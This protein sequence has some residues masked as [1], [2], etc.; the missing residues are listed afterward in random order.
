MTTEVGESFLPGRECFFRH[1]EHSWLL[2]L[3]EERRGKG[4]YV[5][6]SLDRHFDV[7]QAV[8]KPADMAP[9]VAGV[10]DHV[11]DLLHLPYLH[12]SALLYH[13]RERYFANHI[14]TNIGPILLALNPFTFD[15]PHYKPDQMERYIREGVGGLYGKSAQLPHSWCTAHEAYWHMRTG[16]ENQSILVSGESGAGKTEAVKIVLRYLATCSTA[17]ASA[18]LRQKVQA[19]ADRVEATSP[20][21]EAFG[22]ACTLLNDNS[23]RFGKFLTVQFD[24]QGLFSGAEITPYLLEKSRVVTHAPRERTYHAFYQ[25]L[26]G[27]TDEERARWQLS[28]NPQDYGVTKGPLV[29]IDGVD[30]AA[31][32]CAVRRAMDTMG[33]SPEEQEAVYLTCAGILH[34][35]NVL[36]VDQRGETVARERQPLEVAARLWG[37]DPDAL[38]L[39]LTRKETALY[40]APLTVGQ[41]TDCRDALCKALYSGAFNWLIDRCN[42][43]LRAPAALNEQRG[44]WIGLLDIFGFEHFE[45][46]S[47][48]QLCINL[49]N[50]QLQSHYNKCVF[51]RDM[52]EYRAEGLAVDEVMFVDNQPTLDLL[53]GRLGVFDLLDSECIS[54]HGTDAN[55]LATLEA[56]L[57]NHKSKGFAR[58]RVGQDGFCIKHY[59]AT[60]EYNVKGFREKNLDTLPDSLRQV[61]CDARN[62]IIAELLPRPTP[63]GAEEDDGFGKRKRT[64]RKIATVSSTF[65]ASLQE[66]MDCIYNTNPHW[67]RCIKPHPCRRPLHFQ[68][69]SVLEQMQCAGVLETIKIRAAGYSVR[70][71]HSDFVAHYKIVWLAAAGNGARHL[72]LSHLCKEILEAVK[73]MPPPGA[74]RLDVQIGRKKV[75][76]RN[77]VFNTLEHLVARL[78]VTNALRVQT[79]ARCLRAEHGVAVRRRHAAERAWFAEREA[80]TRRAVALERCCSVTAEAEAAARRP[81]A[82]AEQGM[83][84]GIFLDGK[85]QR[86]RILAKR[87]E[88]QAEMERLMAKERREKEAQEAQLRA[89][90]E[91]Q[92]AEAEAAALARLQEEQARLQREREEEARRQ[93]EE[94][95]AVLAVLA[96]EKAALAEALEEA[97]RQRA[98][99]L[100]EAQAEAEA[101]RFA[102]A[103]AG[104]R[105]EAELAAAAAATEEAGRTEVETLRAAHAAELQQQQAAF[106]EERARL[107]EQLELL[108]E[109]NEAL[110]TEVAAQASALEATRAEASHAALLLEQQ[111]A[112]VRDDQQRERREQEQAAEAAEQRWA[113]ERGALAAQ[114]RAYLREAEEQAA[115]DRQRLEALLVEALADADRRAAQEREDLAAEW[116]R[117]RNALQDTVQQQALGL[118]QWETDGQRLRQ[119]LQGLEAVAAEQRAAQRRREADLRAAESALKQRQAAFEEAQQQHADEL[120]TV[121]AKYQQQEE[122]L[123]AKHTEAV[124][125]LQAAAAAQELDWGRQRRRLETELEA[126]QDRCAR[127]KQQ[128]SVDH[129]EWEALQQNHLEKLALLRQE[130]EKQMAELVDKHSRQ[131]QEQQEAVRGR[132][133]EWAQQRQRLQ[134][135]A[136]AARREG[137]AAAEA[138]REE[139]QRCADEHEAAVAALRGE[140]AAQVQAQ[141]DAFKEEQRRLQERHEAAVEALRGRHADEAA[142]L[143]GEL[144]TAK[145]QGQGQREEFAAAVAEARDEVAQLQRRLGA[146]EAERAAAAGEAAA[147]R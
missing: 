66:L 138:A 49:A 87:E 81:I 2:G 26:Y 34:L 20:I 52:V 51:E 38:L 14:Y 72:P 53:V 84:D 110:T 85:L 39:S 126:L 115:E 55:Y 112:A 64:A 70:M 107:E 140:H 75:F 79:F 13:V 27:A 104:R 130:L 37:V 105:R 143:A 89:E 137:R 134:A 93:R 146:A 18:T 21:L 41:A 88:M 42:D 119:Q 128:S 118:Q 67:I 1:P 23:S 56:Q 114:H 16:R 59:A 74:A 144:A 103:E 91:R 17:Q 5:V 111:L 95:E 100:A 86:D 19:I 133:A 48:E 68:G 94:M 47:F 31:E 141:A 71:P 33:M 60:V 9:V 46:N 125:E 77:N 50:E 12:D 102:L 24:A 45:R 11:R 121:E 99:E 90:V 73:C 98:A 4:E 139:L 28:R 132:E 120:R 136:E 80:E 40:T 145:E 6:L 10:K 3:V 113:E 92:R 69:T 65:R 97:Q 35:S 123:V 135:E 131:Q 62:P 106:E 117:Q 15:I 83:F 25:V 109:A 8:V 108:R 29:C 22:N 54:Q 63:V 96:T 147:L 129:T 43:L 36:F 142:R 124:A 32:Y 57:K 76:M 78:Q 61:M 30:D 82:A 116:G 127:L 7:G 101:E 44:N 58:S 122:E